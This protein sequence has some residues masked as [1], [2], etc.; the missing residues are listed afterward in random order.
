MKLTKPIV[1][2]LMHIFCLFTVSAQTSY[3]DIKSSSGD[4][5]YNSGQVPANLTGINAV[6]SG[7]TYQWQQSLTPLG[8][9]TNISGATG[10]A[11]SFSTALSQSTYF[12]R[13]VTIDGVVSYSNTLKLELVSVNWENINY[14]REHTVVIE[15]QNN[16]QSIDQLTIGSK[17]EKTTYFDNFGRPLQQ[18]AR[19]MATP[20]TG[21]NPSNPWPDIIQ[22]SQYDAYGRITKGYLPYS[23]GNNSGKYKN[24]FL[25]EQSQYYLN[26]YNETSAFNKVEYDNSPLDRIMKNYQPGGAW[27]ASAGSTIQYDM[28]S[29]A[30]NVQE[31]AIGYT[32]G[33]FPERIAAYPAKKLVKIISTNE[34]GKQQIDFYNKTGQHI[35]NKTQLA[36]VPSGSYNGWICSYFVYDEFGSL[37]FQIQPE[38]VK[39]LE[40]NSWDFSATNGQEIL[41]GFCFSYE[42]DRNGRMTLK[43]VPGNEPI[44]ILYD[45]KG[46]VVFIQDGN[47][48]NKIPAEWTANIYD[49]LDR[50]ALTTLYRTN[51]TVA[52]L[53]ADIDAA[54]FDETITIDQIISVGN[55]LVVNQRNPQVLAYHATNSI[56]FVNG[57][58]SENVDM[59][60]GE[61]LPGSSN[62]SITITLTHVGSPISQASLEDANQNTILKYLYYDN[63]DFAGADMFYTNHQNHLAYNT[64]VDPIDWSKRSLN[65]P[66]G[67]M[68]RILGSN[69]FLT[70]TIFYDDKGRTIQSHR[71]NIKGGKDISTLQYFFDGR[72]MSSHANHSTA[73]TN[74]TSFNIINKY[75]H[76]KIGRITALQKKI[77]NNDFS[78]I[79]NYRMDDMG[80]LKSRKLAPGYTGTGGTRLEE[81]IYSYNIQNNLT[82]I[83]KDYALKTVGSYNK[84]SNYF[85]MYLGYENT[86]NV[87]SAAQLTGQI[88][89][90]AWNTQGDDAQRKYDYTYDNAGRLTQAVFNERQLTSDN[91]S[92]TKMDF[93]ITGTGGKIS[94]D[95]NGNLLNM[96]QKGVMPGVAIPV[97]IDDL[98]Y[99]YKDFSNQLL[100]VADNGSM[101][102]NNGK[103]RDFK[104]GSNGSANDYLYDD[105]GNLITDLNKDLKDFDGT[106][107]TPGIT[108]N[109]L[110]KPEEI[111]IAG[112][113]FIRFVY[114]ADGE[115]LQKIF[116]PETGGTA[117]ITSYI[118]QF[119]YKADELQYFNFEEGRVRVMDA[120]NED[121]GYDYL[122]LDGNIDLPGNKRGALDFFISDY[123]GNVRMILTEEV[124]KGGN[125]CTME[126]GRASNE[127]SLFGKVDA[128]GAPAS[129][130]EVAA[131]FAV[132]NIPG[133][134][135]GNGW[136]N[137]DIDSYVSRTGNL[138][139]SKMGPNTLLKVMAGDEI[140]ATTLYFYKNT[141]TNSNSGNGMLSTIL[142]GLINAISGS[143]VT[144]GLVKDGASGINTQLNANSGFTNITAPDASDPAG[145]NP[146]AYLTML[147]FDERFNYVSE[148]STA[149]RVQQAGN[150]APP[151]AITDVKAPKNGYV[152]IYVS[153][154]DDEHVYFDNI[155]VTHERG[156]ILEENHYYSYGLKISSISSSK[157]I[158][159]AEGHVLNNFLYQG[160]Y[161][162]HDVDL[163]WNEFDLRSY[164][165]QTGRFLQADPYDQFS[166]PYI[167]M[168]NNP[169]LLS[170]PNGGW[171]AK[172]I[173]EG[174]SNFGRAAATTLAG[175]IVGGV[176]DVL[177][178][179]DG[180][181]G[182]LIGA[183]TGLLSNFDVLL[184]IGA[185]M[186]ARSI[187]ADAVNGP[188][189]T[190]N[191]LPQD[192][193][194]EEIR[195][196]FKQKKYT[197]GL[198]K[199]TQRY[200]QDFTVQGRYS[201]VEVENSKIPDK[202]KRMTGVFS[203]LSD[204][205][206]NNK[207]VL[208]VAIQ[209]NVEEIDQ[210]TTGVRS[211]GYIVTGLYHEM[212]HVMQFL[213]IGVWNGRPTPLDNN[214]LQFTAIYLSFKS[215]TIP[216]YSLQEEWTY[217]KFA[218]GYF[219][220]MRPE[221][222]QLYEKQK[223]ELEERLKIVEKELKSKIKK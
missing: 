177:S 166:S 127:E 174:V 35:L 14:I 31:F 172:G 29:V 88:T 151:L 155:Q 1:L 207:G 183:G 164:D 92:H 175:A 209:A 33:A 138:A 113:G 149:L 4:Y 50:V 197:E 182:L 98:T 179:G 90:I 34:Y 39:W 200:P 222:Q 17:L 5:A 104:D 23:S 96:I 196:L 109:F 63:Y 30:D 171:A 115:K 25:T 64:G 74:Y 186:K 150:D 100:K 139:A 199:I 212:F 43:K 216:K 105:N 148:G 153:N 137:D 48:R 144:N 37:R 131:R 154:Q 82:G 215:K 126:T 201:I 194:E 121:N 60:T 103:L 210:F 145:N 152:Y 162:E 62:T 129:G 192:E 173:F 94:Y 189:T 61:I 12:R 13:K 52:Q 72:L 185:G 163:D 40:N 89:G 58:E 184:G 71:E 111:R 80:R 190:D 2:L 45:K 6:I 70:N 101:S 188:P 202:D 65:K 99:G 16:W 24:N 83:N 219:S 114:T 198:I 7:A 160:L 193:F 49:V 3:H 141:V 205:Y 128:N 161:S 27:A 11:Y 47:Q 223:Q 120:V 79:A 146:K 28:N 110:D 181:A 67:S 221:T 97:V 20:S 15:G 87:F 75:F 26:V 85:G 169:V 95:L 187:A 69:Q 117:A 106:P 147:F 132:A 41:N 124:H 130:N 9:Y 176:I 206:R 167:G 214:V 136:N 91:W 19:E 157:I 133:Q 8:T 211:F 108:Y 178:G 123:Q 168:G 36:D 55:D 170:D 204:K 21:A 195:T 135:S 46:R 56:E 53:Q 203:T 180:K 38:A 32:S 42:Y 107:G 93:A 68:I 66:T 218:L 112:K 77:G 51:K 84:W 18:V 10:G 78:E 73:N 57:F 159:P 156:R 118:N 102:T 125:S 140:S 86:D 220:R 44:Y 208:I 217:I 143:T 22:F 116:T 134:G 119:V 165:A 76:D 213:S 142:G 59:F 54:S 81:L 191:N 158:N 122:T